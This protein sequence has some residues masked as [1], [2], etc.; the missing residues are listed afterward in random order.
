MTN[1]DDDIIANEEEEIK[2]IIEEAE[3]AVKD[4]KQETGPETKDEST[5]DSK[6][7]FSWLFVG[8][9]IAI[10]L[11]SVYIW[12]I[13]AATPTFPELTGALAAQD[14]SGFLSDWKLENSYTTLAAI[15]IDR[16]KELLS[17][18]NIADAATWEFRNGE[19]S[20]FVW[21]KKYD[22]K[23]D[24]E[25]ADDAFNLASWRPDG[26]SILGFGDKSLIGIYKI[27]GSD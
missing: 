9:A 14:P 21:L 19:K 6:D 3:K 18:A 24:V 20:I 17:T 4:K 8:V 26:Q 25:K 1:K 13:S 2:K 22:S 12:H 10:V 11:G 15:P 16:R 23:D 5:N 7:F 27:T